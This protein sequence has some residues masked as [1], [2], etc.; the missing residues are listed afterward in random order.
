MPLKPLS[1]PLAGPGGALAPHLH[2]TGPGLT[3]GIRRRPHQQRGCRHLLCLPSQ[4]FGRSRAETPEG[5]RPAFA[6]GD[7][8]EGAQPLCRVR[9]CCRQPLLPSELHGRRFDACS[10]SIEQRPCEIRPGPAPPAHDTSYGTRLP[11][12][13]LG[14]TWTLLRQSRLPKSAEAAPARIVAIPPTDLL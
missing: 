7:L 3:S 8:A 10:S 6:G 13:A 11:Q 5:S 2:D 9:R 12:L 4:L 1:R 14:S